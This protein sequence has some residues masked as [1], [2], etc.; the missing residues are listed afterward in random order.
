MRAG[1]PAVSV[2]FVVIETQLTDELRMFGAPAFNSRAD[3]E[4]HQ[5]IT[6]VSEICQAIFDVEIMN[7]TSRYLFAFLRADHAGKRILGLPSCYFLRVLNVFEIDHAH[8]AGCVI[9]EINI[10]VV[11]ECAMNAAGYSC[12]VFGK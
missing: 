7:V 10:S 6:P 12:R 1:Q 8:R 9:G 4:N 3:V 2:E 5:T 11:N